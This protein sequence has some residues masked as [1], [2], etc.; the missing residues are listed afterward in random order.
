MKKLVTHTI[1][2]SILVFLG[3]YNRL[4]Y[5]K[6]EDFSLLN[7]NVRGTFSNITASTSG[8]LMAGNTVTGTFH[9][10]F[11]NLGIISVR[12]FNMD[13]DS[14]D[15]LLFRVK[16]VG[17]SEWFYEA[18]YKT[19]QFQPHE[20]FP[21]GFPVI[22]NSVDKYYTFEI[23]SLYGEVGNGILV[24]YQA[25]VFLAKSQFKK[26]ELEGDPD[27]MKYFIFNKVTN[28]FGGSKSSPATIFYFLPLLIYIVYLAS[29][30]VSYQFLSLLTIILVFYDI[31]FLKEQ[32][33]INYLAIFFL[34][35]LTSFRFKISSNVSVFLAIAMLISIPLLMLSDGM[36]I[37][38]KTAAW[39]SLF[40]LSSI[41]QKIREV[42]SGS[43]DALSVK[44]FVKDIL[45]IKFEPVII[46]PKKRPYVAKFI[47]LT[48]ALV[49][50]ATSFNNILNKL[51]IYRSFYSQ[52]YVMRFL[53]YMVVPQVLL[54]LFTLII[55]LL[56]KRY[57]KNTFF[58]FLIFSLIFF[59]FSKKM[60]SLMLKFENT[61]KIVTVTPNVVNEV[62]TDVVI[63]GKNF[64][65]MP[66]VGRIM[67]DGIEQGEYLVYWSDEKIIFRTSPDLT[68]SGQLQVIPLDKTPSN[69]VPFTYTFN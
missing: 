42:I 3:I 55:F 37:A 35:I 51:S 69:R 16:E 64:R 66:F 54:I 11:P 36:V 53:G 56:T 63:S 48:S 33:F 4:L 6:N 58:F 10:K 43:T 26:R 60:T 31:L 29:L 27:L 61:T 8:E 45:N 57:F 1:I 34:W 23:K 67:I 62:W 28:M 14:R 5:L 49:L 59:F 21:F 22:K 18:L 46:H 24:D 47:F 2:L 19:D 44:R 12:F 52:N 13:R 38:E 15:T 50:L 32:F 30:G 68:K 25:P 40:L 9:S 39:V 20:L 65:N 41:L 7:L 17:Q